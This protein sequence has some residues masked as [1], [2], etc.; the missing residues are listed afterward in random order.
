M[1][2]KY[3]GKG[4]SGALRTRGLNKNKE[5]NR[6]SEMKK[7][8]RRINRELSMPEMQTSKDEES[9]Q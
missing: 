9:L 4:S 5:S 1:A 7:S 8:L 3:A 2:K 6:R